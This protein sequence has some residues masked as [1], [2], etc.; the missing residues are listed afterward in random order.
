MLDS[1]LEQRLSTVEQRYLQLEELMSQPEVATDPKRLME[2]GRERSDLTEIVEAYRR[3]RVISRQIHE[4]EELRE[5]GDPDL[6]EM[7]REEIERLQTEDDSN[8]DVI[9]RLLVPKDPNDDRDVVIEIRAG[10]GGDEAGLFGAELY[11]M[12]ARYAERQ[13]WK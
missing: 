7:A 9:K 12:Y 3:Y 4:A 2:L 10:A 6:A 5:S 1:R 11:S 8:V 13:G